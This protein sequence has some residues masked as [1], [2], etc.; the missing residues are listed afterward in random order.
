MRPGWL[1]LASR[2]PP[3]PPPPLPPWS[4]NLPGVPDHAVPLM[5][6]WQCRSISPPVRAW[7]VALLE[8][9]QEASGLFVCVL[10]VQ[11]VPVSFDEEG[12]VRVLD[13]QKFKQTEAL[14]SECSAFV[15]SE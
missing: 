14:E 3:Q 1:S 12:R 8:C 9:S 7:P 6:V 5:A 10:A 13:A 2:A 15:Q 4:P 11:D